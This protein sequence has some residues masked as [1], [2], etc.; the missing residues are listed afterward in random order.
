[1]TQ[2]SV[3]RTKVVEQLQALHALKAGALRTFDAILADVK[4]D[5]A[6]R[7][8]PSVDDLLEKMIGAF[9]GHAEETREHERRLRSRLEALGT[10]TS[11]PREIGITAA[12]LVR[13]QLGRIGG[14][15]YG[16]GARDAFVYEHLEIASLELL[17]RLAHRAGDTETEELARSVREED[18]AMAATIRRNFENVL[19]LML[20]GAGL[21]PQRGESD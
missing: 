8:L 12:A 21:D 15:N 9:G 7:T 14:L 18:E 4:K 2:E 10:A 1:M 17:E 20:A 6:A 3:L 13:A 19:S 11:K 5:H 16:S